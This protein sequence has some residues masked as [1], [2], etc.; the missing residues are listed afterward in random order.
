LLIEGAICRRTLI[1]I[2]VIRVTIGSR[3]WRRAEFMNSHK[4][5][6]G[7]MHEFTGS[8]NMVKMTQK[9]PQ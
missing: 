7:R 2:P 9:A 8:S 3:E 1:G 5:L 6:L 4:P